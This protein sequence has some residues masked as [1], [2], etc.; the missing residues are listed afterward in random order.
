M[1]CT[2]NTIDGGELMAVLEI[3]VLPDPILSRVAANVEVVDDPIC[4]LMDDM[5]ETMYQAPGVGL[6]APQVGQSIR[7]IVADPTAGEGEKQ[8]LQIVNPVIVERSGT[9]QWEEGCLSV[10]GIQEEVERSE[11]VVVEGLGRDG[12]PL[13]V[14]AEGLLAVIL[15]HEIDHLDGKVFVDRL[16]R[17]RR[18]LALR[19]YDR[20]HA[21]ELE[22]DAP[23]TQKQL[24]V[25]G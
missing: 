14:E 22:E 16:N 9:I 1:F 3:K 24:R 23:Q 20:I 17:F 4:R 8:L 19:R 6:A 12:Q 25:D 13:R 2:A 5:A 10:P 11:K 21:G 18:K 15:Q 7:V